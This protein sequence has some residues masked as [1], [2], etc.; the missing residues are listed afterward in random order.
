M[1]TNTKINV[2][3]WVLLCIPCLFTACDHNV[4]D[5]EDGN[6]S[7]SLAWQDETDH[8]T[9]VK[10]VKIWIFNADNGSLVEKDQF[11][12][13]QDIASQNFSLPKGNYRILT[14]A[15][16]V[17]P[18]IMIEPT[19]AMVEPT[20]AAGDMN[21]IQLGLSNPNAATAHAYYGVTEI[22]IDN[23]EVH[24][25]TKSDM[26]RVLA[27]LSIIINGVPQ[28]TIITGKVLNVATG[29]LALQQNEDGTFG[30]ATK[31]KEEYNILVNMSMSDD[32]SITGPLL[33]MPT[34]YGNNT[35]N[36][37][38]TLKTPDGSIANYDI[39]A[40]IMKPSGKYIVNLEYDEMKPYMYLSS[41]RIDDWTEGWV[42]HGEI[43]NPDN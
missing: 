18:Y 25:I 1:R 29:L 8:G 20:R 32:K 26:R 28:N 21:M 4:H 3:L 42:Y 43:F 10:D 5:D 9:E 33:L 13:P 27:E 2:W 6:L 24:Y 19:R 41:I 37:F 17:E 30:I 38:L 35:T 16:F 39:N 15:N 7:V 11:A 23:E 34:C 31:T 36:L 22:T 12:K 40:P 14:T